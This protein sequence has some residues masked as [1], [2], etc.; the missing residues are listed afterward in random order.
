MLALVN[1]ITGFGLN[2]IAGIAFDPV[3]KI[4]ISSRVR[5]KA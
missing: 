1:S 3:K 2:H 4:K 5:E